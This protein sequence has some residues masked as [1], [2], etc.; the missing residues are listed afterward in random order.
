M[1][2]IIAR[3]FSLSQYPDKLSVQRGYMIY[4]TTAMVV[5]LLTLFG[6]VRVRPEVHMTLFQEMAVDSV[7]MLSVIGLY[8][9]AL[10]TLLLVRFGQL[11]VAA[12]GPVSMWLLG[13]VFP[14]V[15]N[16][17]QGSSDSLVLVILILFA[18][19]LARESGLLVG[20]VLTIMALVIGIL[21]RGN[22]GD[23]YSSERNISDL[24]AIGFQITGIAGVIY[25]FLRYAHISRLEGE[26]SVQGKRIAMAEITT[27]VTRQIS[28][29]QSLQGT[30]D[31]AADLIA[32]S[33]PD[34]YHAQVFLMNEPGNQAE[35]LASTGEVGKLLKQRRHS[36][37][38]GGRS[39]IG[40]VTGTQQVVVAYA[41]TPDTIHRHNDLLPNT[42]VEAAFPLRVGER[43]IG[44]LDLQS[45][46]PGAF[47]DDDIPAFQALAD[48]IAI[49]IENAR[50]F[51]EAEET[52]RQNRQL[53]EESRA[54]TEEVLRLNR[55]LT[56]Q[57][58]ADHLHDKTDDLALN[59]DFGKN[60]KEQGGAWTHTLREALQSNH[61]IHQRNDGRQIVAVPVRVRG[62]V[63]GAMEFELDESG[64]LAPEDILMV[65]EI[66]EQLGLA[67]ENTR[68]YENTQRSAQ[69]EALVNQIAARIQETNQVDATLAVAAR[70]LQEVLKAERVAIRLGTPPAMS[71]NQS[72]GGE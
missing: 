65:E 51:D 50:L 48:H 66:S 4:G 53:I 35:L 64:Q 72:G 8:T 27:N 54:S 20:F 16:G 24:M 11:N 67:A 30:M 31:T 1:R 58:W 23:L 47:T 10:I 56:R 44:A 70:N 25:M 40:Q 28:G 42:A 12:W 55:Q 61:T 57:T 22:L 5:T 60:T 17:L 13:V 34:V 36:L 49:A 68:L 32:A 59:I 19:L 46:N 15:R 71:P 41:D 7:V 69:R 39:V 63:I 26:A 21:A 3:F 43:I 37:K 52:I 45:R 9:L 6:F 18:G 62:E 33:F 14:T 2:R 29:K 38:V